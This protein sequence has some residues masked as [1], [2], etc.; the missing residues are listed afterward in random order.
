MQRGPAQVDIYF[1]ERGEDDKEWSDIKWNVAWC[2]DSHIVTVAEATDW[3]ERPPEGF[4]YKVVG[5]KC[6][7]CAKPIYME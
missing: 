7:G 6:H 4:I 5:L 1:R 2:G 3:L